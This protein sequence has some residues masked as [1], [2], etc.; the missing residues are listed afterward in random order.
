MREEEGRREVGG[1]REESSSTS[2]PSLSVGQDTCG[3]RT[4]M[5][6]DARTRPGK[7]LD[8]LWPIPSQQ[9]H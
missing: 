7:D 4:D 2:E 5:E 1:G 3:A 6:Q 9:E 8:C